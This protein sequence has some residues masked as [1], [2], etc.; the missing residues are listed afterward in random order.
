[1]KYKA[2]ILLVEDDTNLG[3]VLTD[4]LELQNFHVVRATDG[5][6]GLYK[7]VTDKIDLCIIDVML[8]KMDGFSLVQAIRK[9]DK[10]QPIILLSAKTSQEDKLHGLRLGADDYITKPFN[11]EELVLRIESILRRIVI[12]IKK[13]KAPNYIRIGEYRFDIRNMQ[14][15]HKEE[16]I[17]LTRKEASLL[18]LF[19]DNKNQVVS[20]EMAFKLIWHKDIEEED[21]QSRSLDVYVVKLRKYLA[22][23]TNIGIINIHGS[24]YKLMIAK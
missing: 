16:A 9:K 6:R 19:Y 22:S 1:M 8:P 3:D 21:G 5:E 18:Q 23:D 2:K 17:T 13:E 24:G 7:F 10:L 12:K 20:R 11:S 4:Y 15:K 14:L